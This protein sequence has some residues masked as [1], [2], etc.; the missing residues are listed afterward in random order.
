MVLAFFIN[1]VL[2]VWLVI[3]SVPLAFCPRQPFPTEALGKKRYVMRRF[4]PE[5]G[6]GDFALAAGHR[7]AI[8]FGAAAFAASNLS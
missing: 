8:S 1:K 6:A 7:I 3:S 5:I 4:P 2:L